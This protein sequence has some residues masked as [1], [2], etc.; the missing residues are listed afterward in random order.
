MTTYIHPLDPCYLPSSPDPDIHREVFTEEFQDDNDETASVL[1]TYHW[2]EGERK[3]ISEYQY[4]LVEGAVIC[5]QCLKELVEE[6][7]A[8]HLGE[9]V[10]FECEPNQ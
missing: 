8:G 3:T 2:Y 7:I 10:I 9:R 5:K 6:A 1:I 4:R